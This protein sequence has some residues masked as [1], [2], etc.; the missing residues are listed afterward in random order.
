M[1]GFYNSLAPSGGGLFGQIANPMGGYQ[2]PSKL[3]ILAAGLTDIG[4]AMEGR[5]GKSLA[6]LKYTDAL[7]R[8]NEDERERLRRKESREEE[9]DRREREKKLNQEQFQRGYGM[10]PAAM[11]VLGGPGALPPQPQLPAGGDENIGKV[12]GNEFGM[13]E[14]PGG[15]WANESVPGIAPDRVRMS[16]VSLTTLSMP[17]ILRI[18]TWVR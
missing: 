7:A 9:A 13:Q 16:Q 3:A 10:P 11:P 12:T 4:R 18:T 6:Q 2:P 8:H 5:P 1:T 17:R 15:P 14:G